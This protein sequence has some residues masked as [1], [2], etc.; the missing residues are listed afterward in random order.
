MKM[1]TNLFSIFDPSTNILNLPINWLSIS[2]LTIFIPINYWIFLNN[3]RIIYYKLINS[4]YKEFS[5]II[6]NKNNNKFILIFINLFIF[7]IINNL[8]SLFP[9]IFTGTR[10]LVLNLTIALPLWLRI[11]LFGWINKTKNIFI[12]LVPQGTPTVLIPFIICIESIRNIIRPLTLTIRLTANLIAGHLLLTLL[13]NIG[14]KINSILIPLLLISQLLLLTLETAVA[15]IQ[16]YVFSVL[17]VLY[18]REI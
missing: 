8:I 1:I 16:S 5:T 7:I 9:Y 3:Y 14:P 2:I 11:I 17:L 18:S 12:H 10:H 15:I 13:G 6:N 4:L